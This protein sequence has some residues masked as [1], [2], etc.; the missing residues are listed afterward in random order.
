MG[1]KQSKRLKFSGR[2]LSVVLVMVLILFSAVIPYAVH[3]N[4]DLVMNGGFEEPDVIPGDFQVFTTIP[5]WTTTVGAGIEIQDQSLPSP[6]T[7]FEGDQYVEL[8]SHFSGSLPTNSGMAQTLSTTPGAD[9]V[10]SFAY[11][12]RPGVSSASN[13]IEV[14]W[15][16]VKIDEVTGN[17]I[18]LTD[19]SWSVKTYMVSASSSSTVIEFRAVGTQDTLGGW[20]DDV[21]VNAVPN[22]SSAS[23]SQSTLWPPNHKMVPISIGVTD[24]DGDTV[25]VTIDSI[26]QD[27]PTNGTGDGDK[28]PDGSGVGTSTARVRAERS[29]NGDGRIYEIAFTADDGNDGMCSGV[30][31]VGV[32][33]SV[34]STPVNSGATYDSTLP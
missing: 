26:M 18:G 10:L 19:T 4:P 32:P 30:V 13:P 20:I 23:P 22:C 12:P 29:G 9:Y 31:Q 16:G 33:H 11:S 28:S 15:D 21:R 34:K 8:D 27:E 24:D 25:A 3:A 1:T 2:G 14:Y 7:P 17:G 6:P 5:G